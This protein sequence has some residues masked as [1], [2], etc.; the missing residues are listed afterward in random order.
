MQP[1]SSITSFLPL[2]R[3]GKIIR[4][5]RIIAEEQRRRAREI[6]RTR[7]FC[8][9]MEHIENLIQALG[10]Q[11]IG[12]G[13]KHPQGAS[14]TIQE[15]GDEEAQS[16]PLSPELEVE[17]AEDW[18]IKIGKIGEII[19]SLGGALAI[20]PVLDVIL[21]IIDNRIANIPWFK[22]ND[23]L[24]T[25]PAML[26]V[27]LMLVLPAIYGAPYCHAKLEIA[28]RTRN[29]FLILAKYA[30][31]LLKWGL[32]HNLN[33]DHPDLNMPTIKIGDQEI[34]I[35]EFTLISPK[36]TASLT[37]KQ[38]V[39]I[40]GD[41]EQHFNEYVGLTIIAIVGNIKNL[42]AQIMLIALSLLVAARACYP[43]VKTCANTLIFMNT[44]KNRQVIRNPSASN[45]ADCE[46]KFSALAKTPAV[47]YASFLSFQ[48]MCLG[49]SYAGLMLALLTTKGNILTQYI[50]NSN[51]QTLG[52]PEVRQT[53]QEG[54]E[55]ADIMFADERKAWKKL[56]FLGKELVVS[57]A[58]GTGNERSEP[59]TITV[60]AIVSLAGS[61][62]SRVN[63]SILAAM[64]CVLGTLTAFSEARN[65]ADHMARVRFFNQPPPIQHSLHEDSN[66][67]R[68]EL[69]RNPV[70]N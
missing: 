37:F 26:L 24:E 38:Q 59:I 55:G 49:N 54:R 63:Q 18:A 68:Q 70:S 27:A 50:I 56:T 29:N 7:L 46:T 12:C 57:R 66:G 60:I 16:F 51:T 69:L 15:T 2:D 28:S 64:L 52:E 1:T 47:F 48:Q 65:A 20:G 10:S 9:K 34:A 43:E 31:K 67:L 19:T 35:D 39:Q 21:R 36:E 23:D 53:S 45:K 42:M 40:L 14:V 41:V 11:G 13:H 4:D 58:V 25:S 3:D 33:I 22:P 44:L 5:K 32:Q 17:E 8:N 30:Q 61:S 62:I 6:E